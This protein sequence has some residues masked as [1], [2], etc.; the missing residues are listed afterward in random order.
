MEE[1]QV[2]EQQDDLERMLAQMRAEALKR[3]KDWLHAKMEE[4]G[5]ER[6]ST[7]IPNPSDFPLVIETNDRRSPPPPQKPNK[8]QRTEGKPAK[9]TPKKARGTDRPNRTP[10]TREAAKTSIPHTSAEGEHISA[11]IKKCL[12]S[13]APLLLRRSGAGLSL[14]GAEKGE[15]QRHARKSEQTRSS[16][17]GHIQGTRSVSKKLRGWPHALGFLA[18]RERPAVTGS[19]RGGLILS[20]AARGSDTRAGSRDGKRS[21]CFREP[22]SGALTRRAAVAEGP[23]GGRI[24]RGRV[25][26]A[27]GEGLHREL[28]A[29]DARSRIGVSSLGGAAP[30]ET[31]GAGDAAA[32]ALPRREPSGPRRLLPRGALLRTGAGMFHCIPLWRCNRHVETIDKRHCSLLA[33]PEDTYRYSRSLEELLLDANQLRELPKVRGRGGP[34]CPGSV[35]WGGPRGSGLEVPGEARDA[36]PGAT[37]A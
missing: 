13:F 37:T 5:E 8:R 27:W 15:S 17:K 16:I 14:E 20:L 32:P 25:A 2:V 18:A 35:T 11:I 6:Q 7:D 23:A 36:E 4:K 29:P 12:E 21:R 1:D 19:G 26:A 22:V 24:T 3:G 33:V 30:H 34:V 9:K 28:G 10:S 31:L